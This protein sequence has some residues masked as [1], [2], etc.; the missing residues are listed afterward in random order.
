MSVVD[1]MM[2]LLQVVPYHGDKAEDCLCPTL[3]IDC[4]CR[5]GSSANLTHQLKLPHVQASHKNKN[6]RG[7]IALPIQSG[8]IPIQPNCQFWCSNHVVFLMWE[9]STTVANGD[10]KIHRYIPSHL[11]TIVQIRTRG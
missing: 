10:A 11:R 4:H 6:A 8:R 9:T 1:L 5:I 2:P 7:W 3:R